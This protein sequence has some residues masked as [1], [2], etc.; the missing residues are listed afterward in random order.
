LGEQPHARIIFLSQRLQSRNICYLFVSISSPGRGLLKSSDTDTTAKL[1]AA[2][3]ALRAGNTVSAHFALKRLLR[4]DPDNIEGRLLLGETCLQQGNL[5][6]ASEI[7]ANLVQSTV[8]ADDS[9]F[10]SRLADLCLRSE[11][12]FDASDLY[13][14][15]W[16]N[17]PDNESL[18]YRAGTAAYKIGR[19][20]L[21]EKHFRRCAELRPE[22]AA[23]YLQ[24]GHV[25]RALRDFD[26]SAENYIE[27]LS[28]SDK[29]KANGYWSLADLRNFTFNEEMIGDMRRYLDACSESGPQASI[30]HFALAIAAEQHED[31]DLA[32]RHFRAAN[33]IQAKLRPFRSSAYLGLI[34]GLVASELPPVVAASA[35]APRP[36]FIVGLPRSG[37]TLVEQILAAHSRVV[38]TDE[39]PFIERIAF[40]L[41]RNGGYGRRLASLTETERNRFREYYLKEARRYVGKDGHFFIDKNPNNFMHVGLIRSLFP[42]ALV[43][44]VRRDLRDNAIS[45]YRQLFSVGHDYSASFADIQT[46]CEGYLRLMAH[47]Q[48]LYPEAIRVQGYE[49]LVTR[50]EQQIAGLLAFCELDSEP[51]CLEFY[52][53]KQ[54]VM[55]PSAS[56]VS[57]PMYSSSIERWRQY[58]EPLRREF[59]NLAALQQL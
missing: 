17:N 41:E 2:S 3:A 37:T 18:R 42:D 32:L 27:Y 20:H 10:V 54:P 1:D 14:S 45:I 46:Y 23:S 31:F 11:R 59:D 36:I 4:R 48:A 6:G 53:N 21:A 35:T 7:A 51:G 47:W 44:N 52:R 39:L 5:A 33:E 16:Q 29:D 55:T 22:V 34:E 8:P 49:D 58:E 28:R 38:A 30:M 13:E 19:V 24:L 9:A 56:Q 25:Y 15:L 40:E 12:Y 43:I 57:Q 50:P 26:R